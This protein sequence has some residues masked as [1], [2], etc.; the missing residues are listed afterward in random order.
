MARKNFLASADE[1]LFG[2]RLFGDFLP[3]CK[4]TD[5]SRLLLDLRECC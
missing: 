2:L 3:G 1:L 5:E 4:G